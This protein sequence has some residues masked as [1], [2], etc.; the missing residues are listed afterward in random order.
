V[1][2]AVP[3]SAVAAEAVALADLAAA[4]ARAGAAEPIAPATCGT[5]G[6]PPAA[7]GAEDLAD[8]VEVRPERRAAVVL[9]EAP[10]RVEAQEAPEPALAW[11]RAAVPE[12]APVVARDPAGAA[13]LDPVPAA[14]GVG[15]ASAAVEVVARAV[16]VE[17]PAPADPEQVVES[18]RAQQAEARSPESG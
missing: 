2:E 5:P 15:R 6:R 10:A 7:P 8:L 9:E 11:A 1:A 12:V 14:L 16:A 17:V 4:Q 3:V 18:V 13:D